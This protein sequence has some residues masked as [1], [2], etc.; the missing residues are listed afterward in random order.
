MTHFSN[1]DLSGAA[2]SNRPSMPAVDAH[3]GIHADVVFG[4]PKDNCRGSGICYVVADHRAPGASRL[5]QCRRARAFFEP[6]A[7]TDRVSVAFERSDLC[8]RLMR[9]VFR[10]SHVTLSEPCVLPVSLSAFLGLSFREVLP[11]L[12]PI[13]VT[14]MGF[15][16]VFSLG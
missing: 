3:Q 7:A 16:I 1:V 15:R 12:Y 9:D 5:G 10:K 2:V 11:G 8:C 6:S 14:A 4:S 13:E